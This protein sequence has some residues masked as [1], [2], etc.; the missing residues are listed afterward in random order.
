M[1][2]QT[3]EPRAEYDTCEYNGSVAR[4]EHRLNLEALPDEIDTRE[5]VLEHFDR[6][7]PGHSLI[8]LDDFGLGWIESFLEENRPGEFDRRFF[9]L[10]EEA[11]R[12]EACV[13]KRAES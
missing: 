4:V 1:N 5:R 6:L 3:S 12:R 7:S 10:H 9:H 2:G 11:G 13:K 8:V